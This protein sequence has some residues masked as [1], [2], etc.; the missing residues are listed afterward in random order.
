MNPGGYKTN[1]KVLKY[2]KL[3]LEALREVKQEGYLLAGYKRQEK[4]EPG[5]GNP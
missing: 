2:W 1:N 3:T 4:E 5:E